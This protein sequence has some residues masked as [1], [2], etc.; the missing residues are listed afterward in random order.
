MARK[1][2]DCAGYDA[3]G[4]PRLRC[5]MFGGCVMISFEGRAGD[6]CCGYFEQAVGAAEAD[7]VAHDME[8]EITTQCGG[9]KR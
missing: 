1:C 5:R 9:N 7:G 3:Q 8:I 6:C 2:E 4:D